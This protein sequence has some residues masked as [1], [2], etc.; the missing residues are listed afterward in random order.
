MQCAVISVSK[1]TW[2]EDIVSSYRHD[3]WVQETTTNLVVN[4]SDVPNFTFKDGLL[5]YKG[6]IWVGDVA[7]LHHRILSALHSSPLGGHSGVPVTY[8]KVK[9][10]FA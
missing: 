7:D 6:R 3:D 5:R 4:D 2:V 1:A 10:F 8:R 9:Q